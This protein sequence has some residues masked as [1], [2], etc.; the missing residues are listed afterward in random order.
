MDITRTRARVSLETP[1][2][3]LFAIVQHVSGS[4]LAGSPLR[5]PMSIAYRPA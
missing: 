5:L 2:D 3:L 1:Q 4:A